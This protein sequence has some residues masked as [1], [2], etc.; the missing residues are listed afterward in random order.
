MISPVDRLKELLFDSETQRLADL[1][2]RLDALGRDQAERHDALTR[3]NSSL[4][5]R[6]EQVFDRA[7]TDDRLQKSVASI[8]DG[9]LKEAEVTKHDELSRAIAPLVVKTIKKEL[10]SAQPELVEAVYPMTGQIVRQY[11]QTAI[12]ELANDINRKLGGRGQTELEARA[13][14]LGVNV[15]D[16]VIADTQA[17]KVDELFLIKRGS[18]DLVAHWEQPDEDGA[19]PAGSGS[20]RDV[21]IAGYLAGIQAFSQEA[22]SETKGSLRSLDMDGQRIFLRASPKFILAARCSGRAPPAV[23]RILDEAFLRTLDAHQVDATDSTNR[24]ALAR[25]S[26][27]LSARFESERKR[28]EAEA[29]AA[30]CPPSFAR[31][32]VMLAAILLPILAWLSWQTLRQWQDQRVLAEARSVLAGDAELRSYPLT[33]EASGA[34]QR[35]M[36]RGLVSSPEARSRFLAGLSRALPG[37]TIEHDTGLLPVPPGPTYGFR[38]QL[39]AFTRDNAVFFGAGTEFLDETS[40]TVAA[41]QLAGLMKD[42][43]AIVRVI[44]YTDERGDTTQNLKLAEARADRV[45]ELLIREGVPRERLSVLGRGLGRDISRGAGPANANRRVV[46]ELGYIGEPRP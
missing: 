46:F 24:E 3:H 9:A 5:E 21:L 13:R 41:R 22:F 26:A 36:V 43:D 17:L 11:V 33:L 16:L 8:L 37:V 4:Q 15:S 6:L 27:S 7:G 34:G 23:E 18:G 20:N 30:S 29:V 1:Q 42:N 14:S 2:R 35:L 10:K 44:G 45:A 19:S 28:L 40:A 31:L 38:E 39:D 32:Y 25:L 12:A